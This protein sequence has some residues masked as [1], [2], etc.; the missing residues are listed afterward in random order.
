MSELTHEGLTKT[1][2]SIYTWLCRTTYFTNFTGGQASYV[3]ACILDIHQLV[4]KWTGKYE[5]ELI[6]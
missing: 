4:T 3:Y 1:P 2:G 6:E 5:K